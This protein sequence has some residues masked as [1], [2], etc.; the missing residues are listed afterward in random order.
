MA[1]SIIPPPELVEQWR[2]EPEFAEPGIAS[3]V[4]MTASRLQDVAARA[5]QYGAD[6]ELEACVEVM[7]ENWSVS[8]EDKLRAARRPSLNP[9]SLKQQALKVLRNALR[10]GEMV[11]LDAN[12]YA[13]LCN[14][15]EA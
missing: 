12:E 6:R 15:L 10:P 3:M 4:S 7:C 11:V 9:P 1:E 5:A 8:L 14:A 13:L 2:L